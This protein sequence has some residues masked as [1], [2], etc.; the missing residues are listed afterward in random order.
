MSP[1]AGRD[2]TALGT[3]VQRTG[4][5]PRL[6]EKA[7]IYGYRAG[8]WLMS[9]IPVRLARWLVSVGL[10]L[11]FV[12]VPKKRRYVNDNFAHV[13]GKPAGSLEVKRKALAAY[14][15]YARYVV[16]LMRL[17]RLT[18]EQAAALVDTS[19]L[20]ELEASWKASG[21]GLIITSAHIGNLEGVARGLARHGWPI[22][23]LGDDSSFP[24]LF[25]MLRRQRREWGVNLIPWRN[26]REMFGVMRRN[27]ILALVIDWGYREDDIPVRLFDAWTTLPAG[28]AAIAAKT[29]APII[30]FAIRRSDDRRTFQLT[31]G[32]PIFVTSSEPAEL[33]RATQAIADQLAATIAAA[34]EQWYSFKPQWPSSPE[35]QAALARRA[36]LAAAGT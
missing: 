30:H 24:E 8:M 20:L 33:Q 11:S 28:P 14:R 5:G 12:L 29:G 34:P 13:L 1:A 15:T 3:P 6:V 16:E 9:R 27:E 26:L 36:E 17:P 21:K 31:H 19:S 23:S 25:D 18:N 22:S 7:A 32:D 35:E 4:R 2:R 10:Q